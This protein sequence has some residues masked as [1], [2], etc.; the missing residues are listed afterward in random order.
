M[1]VHDRYEEYHCAW[2]RSGQIADC[3]ENPSAGSGNLEIRNFESPCL[4]PINAMQNPKQVAQDAGKI[5]R[6]KIQFIVGFIEPT[7]LRNAPS[8]T[9]S[10]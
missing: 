7:F 9:S 10:P 8:R 1:V 5:K 2:L 6:W 4:I 3:V